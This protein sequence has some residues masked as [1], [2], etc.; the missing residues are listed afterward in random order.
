M[1]SLT[2]TGRTFFRRQE[3]S[4]DSGSRKYVHYYTSLMPTAANDAHGGTHRGLVPGAETMSL[5]PHKSHTRLCRYREIVD[6]LF[7]LECQELLL[8]KISND[9]V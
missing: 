6:I 1:E 3:S 9:A 5:C 4:T 7:G 8:R 2:L